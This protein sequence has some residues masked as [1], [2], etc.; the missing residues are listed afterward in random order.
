MSYPFL[1]RETWAPNSI[2]TA[3]KRDYRGAP[4]NCVYAIIFNRIF[5]YPHAGC[6]PVENTLGSLSTS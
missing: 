4:R 1:D 3:A 2:L 5:P 6:K